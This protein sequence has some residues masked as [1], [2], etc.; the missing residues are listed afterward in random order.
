MRTR[1]ALRWGV[2]VSALSLVLFG[3]SPVF[4]T[5][6]VAG[7][8]YPSLGLLNTILLFVVTPLTVF[9]VVAGL[10]VL[11]STLTNRRNKLAKTWDH[12][13][14]WIASSVTK[15]LPVA[16][17]AQIPFAV[18]VP[19]W[20]NTAADARDLVTVGASHLTARGGASAEW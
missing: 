12:E 14:V 5:V 19:A 20:S 2:L 10:A 4:A 11:P 7:Q 9:F 13:P 8:H 18:D 17:P 6:K 1:L 15:S 16:S 3:A